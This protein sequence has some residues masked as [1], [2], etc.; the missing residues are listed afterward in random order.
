MIINCPSSVAVDAP[1]AIYLASR[2][3]PYSKSV[4]NLGLMPNNAFSWENHVALICRR[5]Y[6]ALRRLWSTV[7]YIPVGTRRKLALSLVVPL[8]LYCDVSYFKTSAGLRYKLQVPF[9]SCA[10]VFQDVIIFLIILTPFLECRWVSFSVSEYVA[11]CTILSRVQSRVT[12]LHDS[13]QFGR[14]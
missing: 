2:Q 6:L 10:T 14:S 4:K 13:I 8:F 3:V 7:S 9:N 11:I 5:V 1:D 12:Y